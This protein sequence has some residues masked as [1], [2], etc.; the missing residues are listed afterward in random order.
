MRLRS[1]EFDADSTMELDQI[2]NSE[3]ADATVN[4]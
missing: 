4:R 3:I 2:L 1:A